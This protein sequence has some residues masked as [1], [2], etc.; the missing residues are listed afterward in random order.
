VTL[1]AE[2][3]AAGETTTPGPV[4]PT[5]TTAKR[6]ALPTSVIVAIAVLAAIT[7][8]AILAPLLPLDDP[9]RADPR[10]KSLGPSADH[11][12]GTDTLGRDL[13]SR[14]IWGARVSLLIGLLSASLAAL[15]GS[16]VG[17]VAGFLRGRTEAVLVSLMDALLAFPSLILAL[18]LTAF[19]GPGAPNVILAIAI[20]SIPVFGRLVRAQTLSIEARDFVLAARASGATRRRILA[21]EIAPNVLPAVAAYAV[22]LAAIAIVVEGT[23]SFLGLGIQLPTP[24][25]GSIIAGGQ[26]EIDEAPHIFLFPVVMIFVT[27]FALNTVGD[28]LRGRFGVEARR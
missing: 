24:T 23:L 9:L 25:W 17:F 11:W 6:R 3:A 1:V 7:V 19:L 16:A 27:V 2:A 14:C 21:T 20:V 18:A 13:F 28:H 10:A 4:A 22:L 15:L 5:T 12:F 8:A 26:G